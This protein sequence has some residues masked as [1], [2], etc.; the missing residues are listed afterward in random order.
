MTPWEVH[1]QSDFQFVNLY[2]FDIF[3]IKP[4]YYFENTIH[5]YQF[6]TIWI[7]RKVSAHETA[8]C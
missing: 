5:F 7:I 1:S 2:E 8:S 3:F 4:K 6:N